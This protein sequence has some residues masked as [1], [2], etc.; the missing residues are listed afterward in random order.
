MSTGQSS[1]A[2]TVSPISSVTTSV[3]GGRKKSA[4]TSAAARAA[5]PVSR[6]RTY[7]RT[8]AKSATIATGFQS[9]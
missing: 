9:R 2:A 8:A 6:L 3:V 1:P 5:Q 4:S 7:A